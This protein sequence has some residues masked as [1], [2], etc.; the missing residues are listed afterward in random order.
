MPDLVDSP[1]DDLCSLSSGWGSRIEARWGAG[2]EGGETGT[3]IC[4]GKNKTSL[5][6]KWP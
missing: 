2:G 4:N 1:R 3:G 5:S 6:P